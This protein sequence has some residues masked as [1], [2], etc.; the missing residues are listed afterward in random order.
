M[1][2]SDS[3]PAIGSLQAR[4][5]K[6]K[7]EEVQIEYDVLLR[8]VLYGGGASSGNAIII[9]LRSGHPDR[10]SRGKCRYRSGYCAW[11]TTTRSSCESEFKF[12]GSE[13]GPRRVAAWRAAGTRPAAHVFARA[14]DGTALGQG[15]FGLNASLC[16][17][18]AVPRD[19]VRV[20]ALRSI[21]P[22]HSAR[23]PSP[24]VSSHR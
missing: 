3:R 1:V 15:I 23:P 17:E 16:R 11:V 9:A 13:R 5:E 2:Q 20:F 8:P 4:G 24:K 12:V 21:L 22:Q 6:R 18:T 19:N 10:Q 14:F 7:R